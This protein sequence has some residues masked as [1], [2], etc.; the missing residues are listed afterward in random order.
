MKIYT[1]KGDDGTTGLIGGVRVHKNHIRV[2]AYGTVDELNS[3][4]GFLRSAFEGEDKNSIQRIQN[5]LFTIGSHLASVPNSKMQLPEIRNEEILFLESEIDR[6]TGTLPELKHFVIPGGS[7]LG[8]HAH[9]ARCVCRRAERLS[10]AMQQHGEVVEEIIIQYLNRLSDY[11]FT[12]ARYCDN[13]LGNGD[14]PWIP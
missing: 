13:T 9:V 2:E 1:K 4:L 6:I 7:A 8:S 10:V 14:L 12:L 5:M 11:L 3:H